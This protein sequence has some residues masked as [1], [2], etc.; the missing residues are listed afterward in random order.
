[1]LLEWG[2]IRANP[3]GR[4]ARI[5]NVFVDAA[6]RRLGIARALTQAVLRDCEDT[7]VCEFNLAASPDA[8]HLYAA[9]GFEAYPAEMRRRVVRD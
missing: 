2:P 9:L 7:G 4:M 8:Q 3:G 1:M 6:W 5:V